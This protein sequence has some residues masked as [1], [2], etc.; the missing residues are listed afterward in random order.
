[1]EIWPTTNTVRPLDYDLEA[2][3][4]GAWQTLE[5]VRVPTEGKILKNGN[6]ARLTSYPDP[7]IFVHQFEPVKADAVRFHFTRTTEGQFPTAE[8]YND[9]KAKRGWDPLPP[10]IQLREIQVF[11]T[12]H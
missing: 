6:I 1:M 12:G 9:L 10:T 3:T 2:H 11:A 4:N 7:W 5:Q 8:I